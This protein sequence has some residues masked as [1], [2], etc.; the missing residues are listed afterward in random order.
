MTRLVLKRPHTHAGQAFQAGDRIDVDATTADWL[1]AH[2]IAAPRCR[3]A[4]RQTPNPLTSNP[5]FP[6]NARNPSHEHLRLLS[7]AASSS[8]SATSPAFPSKCARPATSPS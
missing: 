6:P 8:A 3:A 1:I 4:D 7:K 2:G 5:T